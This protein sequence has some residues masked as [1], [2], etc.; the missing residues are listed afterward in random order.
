MVATLASTPEAKTRAVERTSRAAAGRSSLTQAVKSH[1]KKLRG[2]WGMSGRGQ[3]FRRY[4]NGMKIGFAETIG[5]S[6]GRS[7]S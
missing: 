2:S 1:P 3:P 5:S 7:G 6:R 4:I